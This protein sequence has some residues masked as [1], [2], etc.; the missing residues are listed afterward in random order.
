MPFERFNADGCHDEPAVSCHLGKVFHFS[1]GRNAWWGNR[2]LRYP[3]IN[4]FW[5]TL[6]QTKAE[7]ERR[8]K[9]GSRWHIR[10]LPVLVISGEQ[11]SVI[12]GEIN[13]DAPLWRFLAPRTRLLSLEQAGRAFAPNRPDS[14]LRIYCDKGLVP[15]GRRPFHIHRSISHGGNDVPLWWGMRRLEDGTVDRTER[16]VRRISRMLAESQ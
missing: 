9:R 12:V 14:V 2:S 3:G 4:S 1:E 15:Y 10:E 11:N 13:A 8:R 6:D 5:P 16:L 7:I